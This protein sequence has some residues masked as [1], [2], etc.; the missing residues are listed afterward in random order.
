MAVIRKSENYAV[1]YFQQR[2]S[3]QMAEAVKQC[4][5][6]KLDE[7]EILAL[8]KIILRDGGVA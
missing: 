8:V 4:R 2:V 7:D 1:W 6:A 5:A 3:E